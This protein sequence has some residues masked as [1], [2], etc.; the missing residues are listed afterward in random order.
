MTDQ[1][2]R[3]HAVVG[4]ATIGCRLTSHPIEGDVFNIVVY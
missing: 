2:G 1:I 4:D 3:G